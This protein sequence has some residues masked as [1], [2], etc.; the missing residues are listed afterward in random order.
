MPHGSTRTKRRK[1]KLS[2]YIGRFRREATDEDG[3]DPAD[4]P[5]LRFL[6]T[7]FGHIAKSSGNVTRAHM[8]YTEKLMARMNLEAEA[9]TLAKDWFRQG[10][11]E[12]G[13]LQQLAKK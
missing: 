5:H 1:V 7:A 6:S 3:T 11:P 13:C 9:R 10:K 12:R 8:R 4:L 2:D